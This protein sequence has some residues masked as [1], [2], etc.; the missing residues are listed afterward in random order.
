M[1][2]VATLGTT[3]QGEDSGRR[4]TRSKRHLT[5]ANKG[6]LNES[7]SAVPLAVPFGDEADL[8][9]AEIWNAAD[10]ETREAFLEAMRSIRASSC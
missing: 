2:P 4:G 6:N 9:L 1:N 5:N 8:E 3:G 7:P 10:S